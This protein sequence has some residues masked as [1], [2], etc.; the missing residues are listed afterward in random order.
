VPDVIAAL[1]LGEFIEQ[2]LERAV[3]QKRQELGHF[4]ET[5]RLLSLVRVE[6]S[7]AIL[8]IRQLLQAGVERGRQSKAGQIARE[9]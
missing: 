5:F 6:R 8:T 9:L 4:D 7:T 1:G 3:P 2:L